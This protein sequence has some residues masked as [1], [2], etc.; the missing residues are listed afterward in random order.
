MAFQK[1]EVPEG[2]FVGWGDK[3]GQ[4]VVG[5]VRDYSET[6]GRDF[7]KNQ[8]PLVTV[9]LTE[10]AHSHIKGKWS[11]LESGELVQITCGQPRLKQAVKFA[12]PKRGDL[13]KI[14]LIGAQDTANG[15]MK[16]F[17]VFMDRGA[18]TSVGTGAPS[19]N[20]DEP[21]FGNGNNAAADPW[22]SDEPPF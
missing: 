11:A 10:K 13:I 6:A 4:T 12:E 8:C 22:A 1:V 19:A 2:I 5:E 20:G 9:K 15:P 14:V 18:G 7:D 17:E 21:D 16:L 3:A